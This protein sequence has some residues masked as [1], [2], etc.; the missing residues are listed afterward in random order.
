MD[1][2]LPKQNFAQFSQTV[3]TL[4]ANVPYDFGAVTQLLNEIYDFNTFNTSSV[5]NVYS[6]NVTTARELMVDRAAAAMGKDPLAFRREFLREER[7]VAVLDK[8]AQAGR[9]GRS[10]PAGTAQ[11]VAVHREYKGAIATLV[12]IDCRPQTVGRRIPDAYTGPRVTKVVVAVDAGLPINPL[13]I[14]AQVMGASM[15]GIANALSYSLHL[16]DGHFLEASWDH[17]HYTRQWNVPPEV[18]IHVLPA[19]TGKPSGMGE[20]G[21][22]PSMAATACAYARATGTMPTE[23]PI[24]YRELDFE[25]F[26]FV[27]PI[28][29]SPVEGLTWAGARSAPAKR[30]KRR[31]RT[32]KRRRT[33]RARRRG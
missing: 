32:R 33:A 1:A 15:D 4:T 19:T 16:V 30:R 9:W 14:R 26:P 8:V 3:F 12:E 31:R 10:M 25:P 28:P 27:P 22:A 23:F 6:P 2:S 11:G 7:L 20:F 13:G 17:A 18:E 5:R 29:A 24:N 21:V